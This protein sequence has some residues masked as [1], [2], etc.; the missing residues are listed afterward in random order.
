MKLETLSS[1]S[2]HSPP[3]KT[4][5]FFKI[6]LSDAHSQTNLMIPRKFVRK[7]GMNLGGLSRISL[8]VP[9]GL[10]WRVTLKT[11]NG[12]VWLKN[13]WTEFAR[14]YSVKFGHLLIFKYRGH[15]EFK[16]R[17]FDS[18]STEIDYPSFRSA[19]LDMG[20]SSQMRK[21]ASEIHHSASSHLMR[22][23]KKRVKNHAPND[24][25]HS[26]VFMTQK[27][28][29]ETKKSGNCA[30]KEAEARALALAEAFR[31][32]NPFFVYVMRRTYVDGKG[33]GLVIKKAFEESYKKWKDNDQVHLQVEGK[34]WLVHCDM[35]QDSCRLSSGWDKFVQDN[36]LTVGDVCVFELVDERRR[37]LQVVIFRATKGTKGQENEI[38]PRVKSEAKPARVVAS[39]NAFASKYPCFKAKVCPSCLYGASLTVPRKFIKKYITEDCCHV[40]L[41]NS[42]GE[43][44]LVKCSAY[45][46]GTKFGVGWKSFARANQLAVGDVC[47]FEL[48][49]FSEKLLKVVIIRNKSPDRK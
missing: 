19:K 9:N 27:L 13:G 24:A 16:V 21:R 42:D 23:H 36:S 44:W 2:S 33:R 15:S 1:D 48:M 31:T 30:S 5:H 29:Q 32:D 6:I 35:K 47:A 22:P 39:V 28:Q 3:A 41:E 10:A 46:S 12:D 43:T 40:T 18:S 34:K 14:F 8:K 17:I 38:L 45:E 25:G 7:Y 11:R 26:G 49:N 4:N 20:E 37:L